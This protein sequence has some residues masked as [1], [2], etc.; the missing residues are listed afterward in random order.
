M[1]IDVSQQQAASLLNGVLVMD[2]PKVWT[3]HD[4]VAKVRRM[5]GVRKV[6][7]T[8]T[9]DPLATG[10]LPLCLGRATRIAEYL[11]NS[12]KAYRAT[13]R[14]GVTTDTQDAAG[15][16]VRVHPGPWP[17]EAAIR[18]VVDAAVG[19]RLQVPPMYSAVKVHGV[20]LYKSARAGLTVER[21]ARS[22]TVRAIEILS[23]ERGQAEGPGTID[24]LFEVVCTKGTYVRTLCAE[25]GETLG[26][27]GHLAAL[28]R[29]RVGRFRIEEAISLEDLAALV[30]SDAVGVRLIPL[31]EALA[32]LPAVMIDAAA[33]TCVR[34]RTSLGVDCIVRADAD[35]QSGGPF[36]L[37]ASDGRLLGVGRLV[38]AKAAVEPG[39]P[40]A[41]VIEKLLA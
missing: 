32:E 6:G 5:L 26:T 13:L 29:R 16:V 10:V 33:A 15:T 24:V 7:H 17:D 41:I 35:W 31:A 9:L 4:V 8:G 20:R 30:A 3:S 38:P 39:S 19:T 25:M 1:S 14:L 23:I 11:V 2:K 36:R 40:R 27:G 18:G 22:C 21:P 28:E 34:H 37:H 12:D